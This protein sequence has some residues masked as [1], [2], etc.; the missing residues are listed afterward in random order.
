MILGNLDT[1]FEPSSQPGSCFLWEM[2]DLRF[3]CFECLRKG[4]RLLYETLRKQLFMNENQTT[5]GEKIL[6]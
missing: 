2:R 5:R 4:L 6:P 1:K 3:M